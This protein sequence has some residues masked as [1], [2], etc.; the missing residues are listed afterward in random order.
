MFR[1]G[2]N[3]FVFRLNEVTLIFEAVQNIKLL[4]YYDKLRQ[5][6]EGFVDEE[7]SETCS[8]KLWD[9]LSG[10]DHIHMLVM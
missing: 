6:A 1:H 7:T 4:S 9:F 8:K 3:N 2:T 10:F 5:K